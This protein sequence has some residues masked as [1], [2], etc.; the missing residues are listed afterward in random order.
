MIP[1]M[2]TLESAQPAL[3]NPRPACAVPYAAPRP[4]WFS[5]R[6]RMVYVGL[7]YKII[8]GTKQRRNIRATELQPSVQVP[9]KRLAF[10]ASSLMVN[11][12]YV[13]SHRAISELSPGAYW[14]VLQT[15]AP[16]VD[17]PLFI[18]SRGR[19]SKAAYYSMSNA[20]Q[21]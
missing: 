14:R 13:I 5:A 6:L 1:L 3:H 15:D 18:R 21:E 2:V 9:C 12:L 4:K 11:E 10:S 17:F 7:T 16:L 20:L 19:R 8:S